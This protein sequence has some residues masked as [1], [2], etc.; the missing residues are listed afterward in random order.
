ML[1]KIGTYVGY[2][3]L[4]IVIIA[5]V[6]LAKRLTTQ[7]YRE[8]LVSETNIEIEGGGS[9][10][11]VDAEAISHWLKE[12]NAHPEGD[13]LEKL[14]I[15]NIESVVASHN[16]VAKANVSVTYDGKVDIDILQRE[17]IAR[18]R[19]SGY[20]MYITK[21]GYILP[22]QDVA[23]VHVPVITGDYK[24]L[25]DSKFIGYVKDFTRDTIV[26]YDNSIFQLEDEK[27][28]HYK[29]LIENNRTLRLVK[30]SSPKKSFL[31]SE[32]EYKIL[33][34]AYNE[35][36]SHAIELHSQNERNIK[37]DIAALENKQ[38]DARYKKQSIETQYKDFVALTRF[39]EHIQ[40]DSF[41]S[42]EVV[43]IIALSLIHI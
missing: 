9:N 42:A 5:V 6:V 31:D 25:F 16:A 8:M 32:E 1:K 24:P 11:M 41:W 37:A 3:L 2:T 43:Q 21:D 29:L 26:A 20:D 35:R 22:A 27:I 34:G 7:N 13:T 19:V 18:M 23:S 15:A 12:H 39:I 33:E 4:W 10:P 14:D 28:P 30:R 38:V 40:S 17:P 36:R